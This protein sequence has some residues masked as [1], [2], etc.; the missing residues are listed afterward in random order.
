MTPEERKIYDKK[1][2]L[3]EIYDCLMFSQCY[4]QY[5]KYGSYIPL[6]MMGQ[7]FDLRI[8]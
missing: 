1:K 2:K 6:E 4:V 5:S 3:K 8:A 7:S